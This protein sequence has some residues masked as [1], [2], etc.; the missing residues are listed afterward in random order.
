[1]YPTPF[2]FMN[3]NIKLII[4][5]PKLNPLSNGVHPDEILNVSKIL[6]VS[7]PFRPAIRL[8]AAGPGPQSRRVVSS[9]PLESPQL[10][11]SHFSD[12]EIHKDTVNP[13]AMP[14]H[15]YGICITEKTYSGISIFRRGRSILNETSIEPATVEDQRYFV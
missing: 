5:K 10:L 7:Q 1:M 9:M 3:F 14:V 6:A 15:T 12:G 4:S 13:A 8:D 2:N 11:E